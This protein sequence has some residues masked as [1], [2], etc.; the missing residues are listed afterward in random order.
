MC[1]FVC[2]FVCLVGWLFVGLL[3]CV[4]VRLCNWLFVCMCMY[5]FIAVEVSACL[6]V[7][8]ISYKWS[9]VTVTYCITTEILQKMV[10]NSSVCKSMK[11]Y[12]QDSVH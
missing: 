6:F 7:Y 4:F 5:M 8:R 3:V 9:A 1:S 12:L 2:V 11:Y 10:V